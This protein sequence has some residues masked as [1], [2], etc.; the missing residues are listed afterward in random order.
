MKKILLALLMISMLPISANA[1]DADVA[2]AS[3]IQVHDM[4]MLREQQFRREEVDENKDL[5][6]EKARFWKKRNNAQEQINNLKQEIQQKQQQVAAPSKRSEF[7]QENGKLRIK[8][9]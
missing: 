7:I 4:Q 2:G 1:F 6:E 5:N 3:A 8:Y 9:Y